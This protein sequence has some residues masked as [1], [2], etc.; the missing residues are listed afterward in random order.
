MAEI[1]LLRH[2]QASFGAADYDQLSETG[3]TQALWL[4][5][6]LKRLGRD[7]DRVVMGSMRRHRQTAEGVLQG[8]V[9]S[10]SPEVH[11]GL[12]EYDFQG[13]LK[14]L[15]SGYPQLWSDTGHPRR[16]YYHNMKQALGLWINGDIEHD[17][18]DSW[19]TFCQRIHRALECSLDGG[20]RRTLVV[21]SGGPI[22]VILARVLQVAPTRVR[23]LA[24]Q[25]K[26]SS[27][28][29]LLYNRVDLTLD[30]F[31]DVSH[32]LCEDRH[33]HITHS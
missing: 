27:T 29:T 23:D 19:Q 32:L 31:N 30:S 16:D 1:V 12:E 9:S 7:C 14:P 22:A 11:P 28:S 15:Q 2:G 3:H 8:L 6:H 26:N 21:T 20:A 18:R 25:V 5:Q 17:G 10:Q 4:G 33:R 24:L 13:L